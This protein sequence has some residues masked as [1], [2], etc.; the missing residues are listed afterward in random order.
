MSDTP[1]TPIYLDHAATS[2][3][4]PPVV[5][6]AVREAL[7]KYGG[8][9]GRGAYALAVAT[10]RMIAEAR[11]ACATFFVVPDSS[12]LIFGSG[13]T[14]ALN[15]ALKGLIAPGD[16]VVA[17][18]TERSTSCVPSSSGVS[19]PSGRRCAPKSATRLFTKDCRFISINTCSILLRRRGC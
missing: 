18:S 12:D 8:N 2:W 6:D 7:T 14:E 3:P 16:R 1:S 11:Q 5:V 13:C 17:C 15:L 19:R 10:A 4:K 9:P